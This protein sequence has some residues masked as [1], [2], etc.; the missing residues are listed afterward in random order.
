MPTPIAL[1]RYSISKLEIESLPV[2]S[3]GTLRYDMQFGFNLPKAKG[4]EHK[5]ELMVTVTGHIGK[6]KAGYQVSVKVSG[7][8]RFPE[9]T[10]AAQFSETLLYYG[11]TLLY[12][13]LRGYMGTVTGLF[14]HGALNMPTVN[15]QEVVRQALQ[16]G[17]L[18]GSTLK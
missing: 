5:L 7:V 14:S 15:M 4:G 1:E 16:R 8:F 9:D 13:V 18:D 10:P 2:P 12:G 11:S 17:P 6:K 3:R